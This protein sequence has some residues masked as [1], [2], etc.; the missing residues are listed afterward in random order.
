MADDTE[1]FRRYWAQIT[2]GVILIF[3]AGITYSEFKQLHNEVE[4][5]ND[6]LQKKIKVIYENEDR[7]EKLEKEIAV[8]KACD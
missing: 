1:F 4:V 2:Y 7:I 8:M 3:T 6:R 5:L